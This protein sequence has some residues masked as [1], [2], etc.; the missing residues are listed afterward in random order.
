[1]FQRLTSLFFSDSSTPEDLEEPKPFV[2]EEEEE[3]GWLIIDLPD[4]YASASSK[5]RWVEG[6]DPVSME[7]NP[8]EDLLIEHPSMSVYVTSSSIVVESPEE[9]I[10]EGE[11]P[12]RR[13]QRH[14]PHHSTSLATK[15]AILEKVNQVRRIQRAKHLV[16]KHKFSPKVM[17]RQNRTR[18]CRP[19]RAKHQGSFVYQPCQR[20]YNY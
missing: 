18:E 4:S 16:E 11:L 1:M 5:E 9:Q 12:E 8:M 7:S 2:S 15:A 19:R 6:P 20:Q 14:A 10:S 17:Q 3:D 13:L